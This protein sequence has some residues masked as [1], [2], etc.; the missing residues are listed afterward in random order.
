M[1]AFVL[2]AEIGCGAIRASPLVVAGWPTSVP[3]ECFFFQ[4]LIETFSKPPSDIQDAATAPDD[5]VAPERSEGCAIADYNQAMKLMEALRTALDPVGQWPATWRNDL[6]T[7]YTN[8]ASL[9]ALA[10]T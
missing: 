2:V 7:A 3:S 9:A 4:R 5:P 6:A 10:T 1:A 8:R